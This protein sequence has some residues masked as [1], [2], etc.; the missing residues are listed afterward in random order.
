M[1]RERQGL[2]EL[3]AKA[4]ALQGPPRHLGTYALHVSLS[5]RSPQSTVAFCSISQ[6]WR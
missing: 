1:L 2:V 4:G 6:R 3:H 5:S